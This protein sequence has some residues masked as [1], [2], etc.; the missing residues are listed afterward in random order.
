MHR[1]LVI[2]RAQR[3]M[4]RKIAV[5]R[6]VDERLRVLDARADGECLLRHD[7]MGFVQH[8]KGVARAVADGQHKRL[9]GQLVLT[10]RILPDDGAQFAATA[11]KPGHACAEVNLAAELEDAPAHGAHHARQPV[12]ADVGLGVDE[13]VTRRA[14]AHERAQHMRDA[15]VLR[16]RVQLAVGERARAAFAELHVR[17]GLEGALPGLPVGGHVARA[18]IDVLPA[19]EHD[20][21][22]AV[23]CQRERGKEPGGAH[24][25]HDRA[26]L[27]RAC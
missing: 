5:L 12:R 10:L 17:F 15:R 6:A 22:C 13:D 1:Q 4:A 2:R 18:G 3:G 9:R 20:G 25:H 16:A 26:R 14:E 24:A 19:L 8:G 21:P 27:R 11:N 23:L 7:E